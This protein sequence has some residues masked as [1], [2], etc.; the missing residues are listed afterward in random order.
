M[1]QP[2]APRPVPPKKKKAGALVLVG[3]VTLFLLASAISCVVSALGPHHPAPVVTSL[4]S[5]M[6]LRSGSWITVRGEPAPGTVYEPTLLGI[7]HST[8]RMLQLEGSPLVVATTDPDS[9]EWTGVLTDTDGFNVMNHTGELDYRG[10]TLDISK[11][12]HEKGVA[13]GSPRR[14]VLLTGNTPGFHALSRS[15]VRS[16]WRCLVRSC[17]RSSRSSRCRSRRPGRATSG[18]HSSPRFHAS[19]TIGVYKR[20]PW[21]ASSSSKTRRTFATSSRS[22]S[23]RPATRS[24]RQGPRGKRPT[25]SP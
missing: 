7:R 19:V 11:Y 21:L 24:S 15:S 17:S 23:A 5:A 9:S 6:S 10:E 3:M 12:C 13:C 8:V 22:T 4:S 18:S 14:A 2:Y 16:P 1:A 20:S 25:S